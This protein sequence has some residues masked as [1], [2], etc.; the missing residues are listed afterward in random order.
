MDPFSR[1]RIASSGLD[2]KVLGRVL[3]VDD[4]PTV[5]RS[6]VRLLKETWTVDTADS[7]ERALLLLANRAYD[8]VLTD[9]EMVGRD[10]IWLLKQ[11]ERRYPDVRRVLHSGS[12]PEDVIS[13]VRSGLVQSYLQKPAT[14]TDLQRSLS[15][16]PPPPY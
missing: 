4:E 2:R 16:V 11:V 12:D 13:H 3:L 14:A 1:D 15:D 10:G 6:L 8:A 5:L 7:A 9:Y